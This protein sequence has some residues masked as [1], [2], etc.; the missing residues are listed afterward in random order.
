MGMKFKKGIA[1][2][3]VAVSSF[4]LGA[5]AMAITTS[6]FPDVPEGTWFTESANWAGSNGI[7]KGIDG[8]F[9]PEGNVTR[10]ELATML[11]RYDDYLAGKTAPAPTNR[12]LKVKNISA[13]QPLS[14]GLA[15]VHTAD[16]N[17]NYDGMLAPAELETLAEVGDPTAFKA[18]VEAQTGV[19]AVYDL[20]LIEPM[21]LAEVV[22]NENDSALFVSVIQMAVASNDGYALVDSMPLAAGSDVMGANWDAGFEENSALGSGFAGG[23]PDPAEG[24][25]NLD[26]GTATS[27]QANVMAHD[28]LTFDIM[29]AVMY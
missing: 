18:Y 26:N 17:M 12:V 13:D 29:R 19:V 2:L 28:Q 5:T 4:M 21:T 8:N 25:A 1:T 24:A 3:V 16:F 23:Q 15:V 22:L 20:G 6:M 9:V 11:K 27:P 10:A 7:V 14:P